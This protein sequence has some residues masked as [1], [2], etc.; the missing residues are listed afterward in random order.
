MNNIAISFL[1]L[2]VLVLGSCGSD[3]ET[4]TSNSFAQDSTTEL[5]VNTVFDDVINQSNLNDFIPA[6]YSLLHSATGDLNLDTYPDMLLVL[7]SEAEDTIES[8]DKQTPRP[9]IILLGQQDG[10]YKLG[11]RSDHVVLCGGCGGIYGDPYVGLTIK[12]GYFSAEHYGGSNW[13][14]TRIITFKYNKDDS[15]WYLHKDG[16]DSYHISNPDKVETEVKT[17]KDFGKVLFQ[18]YK[19]ENN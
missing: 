12:D 14:W 10:T 9:L 13:R 19:H 7:K 6:G 2:A 5:V 8:Y 18:D 4:E 16:G 17:T 15:K 1:C 3:T 11:G